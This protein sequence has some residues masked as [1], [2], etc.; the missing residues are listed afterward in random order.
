M[1]YTYAT[2]QTALAELMVTATSAADFVAILPSIIDY[3]EQRCYRDL[4]LLSTVVRD[5]STNLTANARAF[6]LPTSLGRFVVINGVNVVTPV[7]TTTANGTRNPL[8]P[9]SRDV[10]DL[11]WPS[12]AAASASTVPTLFAMIT[13]QQIIVGPPPGAAFNVEIIGTIRPTALS[14]SNTTTSLSTYLPD[15]FLAASMIFASGYQ[16]NFGGQSDDPKMS[17]SWEQQYGTLLASANAEEFRKR[18]QSSAWTSQTA[19]PA[20]QPPRA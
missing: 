15:L 16:K 8:V 20:A 7:A 3:A 6:T 9:T 14:A 19:P 11:L 13:D 4:D 17:A 18:F 5:S 1:S 2:Y 12:E 10:L